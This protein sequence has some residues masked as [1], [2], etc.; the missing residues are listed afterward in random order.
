MEP[1]EQ[2]KN[3]NVFKFVKNYWFII[4]FIF[5]VAISWS[6]IRAGVT[7]NRTV[8]DRQELRIENVANTLN[9][10]DKKYIEDVA[11]IKTKLE[12]LAN[13]K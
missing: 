12:Q 13:D 10:L 5:G 8:N 7:A 3:G 11:I 6:E 9:V 2:V 4:V 1:H